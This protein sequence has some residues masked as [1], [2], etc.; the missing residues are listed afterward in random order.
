M[1]ETTFT[2]QD[3]EALYNLFL[4]MVEVLIKEED[5]PAFRAKISELNNKYNQK[6]NELQDPKNEEFLKGLVEEYLKELD[7]LVEE[8]T[9][10]SPN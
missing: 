3:L 9:N 1:A 2:S 5:K 6:F 10:K 7:T 4:Q 8:F